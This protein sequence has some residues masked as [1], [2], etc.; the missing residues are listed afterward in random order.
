MTWTLHATV[1]AVIPREG[2]YLLVEERIDGSTLFNQPAG[3]LEPGETLVQAVQR[4]VR[5]ETA[6]HFEPEALVGVY[7]YEISSRQRTYLRFCFCGR[8]GGREAGRS[9]DKEIIDTHWLTLAE[10]E[11]LK[12]QLR[13]PMVLQCIR[14]H[15][16]GVRLPLDSLHYLNS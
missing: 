1:A 4:E 7:Q 6:R 8:V 14:D 10:I 3:H 5:E 16:S 15:R 13:S 9:L 2:R 11:D 12:T